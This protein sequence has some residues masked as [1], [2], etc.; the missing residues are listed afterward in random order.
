MLDVQ[1]GGGEE[2]NNKN[3]APSISINLID[4]PVSNLFICHYP[5]EIDIFLAFQ[6]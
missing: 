6:L 5:C 2:A 3:E 4:K 1:D